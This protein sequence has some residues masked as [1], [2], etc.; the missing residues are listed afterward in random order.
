MV[1]WVLLVLNLQWRCT[2]DLPV[3]QYPMTFARL[4]FC[5]GKTIRALIRGTV[6]VTVTGLSGRMP[7]IDGSGPYVL[8]HSPVSVLQL[9]SGPIGT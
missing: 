2:N 1:A 3:A 5:F 4:R 8:R 6:Q 7:C 9:Q